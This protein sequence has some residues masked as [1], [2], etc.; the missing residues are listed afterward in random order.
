MGGP[1]ASRTRDQEFRK[2]LLCP[3]ELRDLSYLQILTKM[4]FDI[5]TP[6]FY[7]G[8]VKKLKNI[9]SPG[10]P[11]E[12][13]QVQCLLRH[14]HSG[15]Y[16]GR[17][18][19]SGKQKWVALDTDV[20]SVAKLRVADEATKF[21]KIR[22]TITE[23]EAGKATMGQI[24]DICRQRLEAN[25]DLQPGTIKTRQ[26]ALKKV[27]KTWAGIEDMQPA[28]ITPLAAKTGRLDSRMKEPTL[29]RPAPR[30]PSRATPPA[31]SIR[32]SMPSVGCLML[33]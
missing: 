17:F 5:S 25:E 30:R 6:K 22:G 7:T 10:N 21:Q 26:T 28:Q 1:G 11:W 14:K 27:L 12:K 2:L 32:P 3:S 9:T 23:V 18:K 20:F 24:F 29:R 16:Y 15:R 8:C 33:L 4:A 31:R 19:V 13:T